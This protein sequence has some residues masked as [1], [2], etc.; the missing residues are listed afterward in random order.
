MSKPRVLVLGGTGFVGRNFVQYLVEKDLTS[1]IRVADKMLPALA[2]LSEAQK[3]VFIKVE[4]KQVNLS[5][6]N[7]I[8]KV[9]D[10]EAPFDYVFNFAGETKYSQADPVYQENIITLSKVCATEAAKRKVKL[11]IEFSTAQVYDSGNKPRKEDAKIKPWTGIAKAKAQAEEELK[12]IQ[13]LN[14]IIVR[15]AIV[16]GPGDLNGITPR[17]VTAAVYKLKNE[18]MEFLWDKDL[19][20]NTV[21]V[22]DVVA[23]VWH[24]S[25]HGKP[26]SIYNLADENDT[27]QGNLCPLLE[28]IFGIQTGFLGSIQSKLATSVAMKT[29]T[30]TANDKH[31][32]PWSDV[33]KQNN[34]TTTPLTPY[35]DEELLYNNH[36]SVDGTA[37]TETG[38]KYQH[39]KVT[40]EL[41]R[42]SLQYHINN[43]SF[44]ANLL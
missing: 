26:N 18:K 24:L 7:T 3:A 16:Y 39:P 6:Q 4:F 23:A 12:K 28:N 29:V 30:E 13:G 20:I 9:Y 1:K 17:L 37:I 32:K 14:L 44:P 10:D 36:L 15:P 11:F 33:C 2:G 31:L 43:G 27:T 5:R 40:I 34:I 21:H 8:E 19:K 38:F 22:N 35:L 42:E 41:L 25:Q